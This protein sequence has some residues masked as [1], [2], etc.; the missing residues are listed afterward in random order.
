VVT[1]ARHHSRIAGQWGWV[2]KSEWPIHFPAH[3]ID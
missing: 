2:A 1:P 3:P